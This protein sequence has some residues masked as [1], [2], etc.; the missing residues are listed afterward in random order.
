MKQLITLLCTLTLMLNSCNSI[1]N[2]KNKEMTISKFYDVDSV[3]MFENH[4]KNGEWIKSMWYTKEGKKYKFQ[5][6]PYEQQ[7]KIFDNQKDYDSFLLQNHRDIDYDFAG[8]YHVGLLVSKKGEIID[9]RVIRKTQ[10]CEP[11]DT[12]VLQTI[13]MM[14]KK[15]KAVMYNKKANATAT[16][17]VPFGKVY[18]K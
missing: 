10:G 11:C 18:G 13:E 8:A 5:L 12:L 2:H 15:V 6:F 16:V 3:L 17:R 9:G 7:V 14:K 4:L 1:K